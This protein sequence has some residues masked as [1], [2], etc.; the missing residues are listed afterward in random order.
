MSWITVILDLSTVAPSLSTLPG[1]SKQLYISLLLADSSQEVTFQGT[2]FCLWACGIRK[3]LR[4]YNNHQRKASFLLLPTFNTS[5]TDAVHVL[6]ILYFTFYSYWSCIKINFE[7]KDDV[8]DAFKP[9]VVATRKPRQSKIKHPCG[10]NQRHYIPQ[11][12]KSLKKEN[13]ILWS[14]LFLIFASTVSRGII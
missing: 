11:K 9:S 5:E 1:G 14:V 2:K 8:T 12:H 4:F 13:W 7:L 3:Q 6:P 10:N